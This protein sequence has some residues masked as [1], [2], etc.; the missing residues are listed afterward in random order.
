MYP[1]YDPPTLRAKFEKY[2]PEDRPEGESWE[3]Q[4]RKI[5]GGYGQLQFQGKRYSAH[6]VAHQLYIG[7]IP[8]RKQVLHDPA[9]CNNPSC[10]NPAHLRIGTPGDNMLDKNISGTMLRG[11]QVHG[12]KL[13]EADVRALREECSY[14]KTDKARYEQLAQR[15]GVV[16]LTIKAA[17]TGKT[18]KHV[19]LS[20]GQ[21]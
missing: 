5:S 8:H 9:I 16:P 12:A 13:T 18:W 14:G 2:L 4:G 15:Y 1:F 17:V 20:E 3:W 6:R 21:S 10:V 7:P 11:E 19:P